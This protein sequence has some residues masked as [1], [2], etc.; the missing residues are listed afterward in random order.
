MVKLYKG[1]T[2]RYSNSLTKLNTKQ[3]SSP[4]KVS[5]KRKNSAAREPNLGVQGVSNL[6]STSIRPASKRNLTAQADKQR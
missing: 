3:E 6:K 5:N 2:G 4:I 1:T